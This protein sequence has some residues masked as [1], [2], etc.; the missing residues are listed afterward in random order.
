MAQTM[1]DLTRHLYLAH[2]AAS[3]DELYMFRGSCHYLVVDK[4]RTSKDNLPVILAWGGIALPAIYAIFEMLTTFMTNHDFFIATYIRTVFLVTNLYIA[5][6]LPSLIDSLL[7]RYGLKHGALC[8]YKETLV[9][10]V[11]YVS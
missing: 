2:R 6:N 8:S 3:R 4:D 5:S 11:F 7:T 9:L 1:E 10:N